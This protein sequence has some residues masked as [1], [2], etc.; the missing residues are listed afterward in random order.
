MRDLF[1]KRVCE[2]HFDDV[3]GMAE[4]CQQEP[5]FLAYTLM[6]VFCVLACMGAVCLIAEAWRVLR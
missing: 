5:T 4:W 1:F 6:A 2:R 3:G